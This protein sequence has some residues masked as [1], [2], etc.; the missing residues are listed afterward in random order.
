MKDHRQERE[1]IIDPEG[2]LGFMII[3]GILGTILLI[4]A[5]AVYLEVFKGVF[6]LV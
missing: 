4:Y 6:V 3:V 2:N 5:V 1:D